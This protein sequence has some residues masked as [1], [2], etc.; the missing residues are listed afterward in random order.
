MIRT[1]AH[2]A[3]FNVHEGPHILWQPPGAHG[4][5]GVHGY[6]IQDDVGALWIPVVMGMPPGAGHT[7]AF[8]ND[9]PRDRAIIVPTVTNRQL[10]DM[11]VRRGFAPAMVLP[12]RMPRPSDEG[13]RATRLA[14]WNRR[15]ALQLQGVPGGQLTHL[16]G[17]I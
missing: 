6:A 4:M 2:D 3:P 12:P 7:S 10:R 1:V 16:D 14:P 17:W 13:T 9:V 8:L 5:E 15:I 11:L